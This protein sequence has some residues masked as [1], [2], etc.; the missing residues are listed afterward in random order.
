MIED[1]L[2]EGQ[3]APIPYHSGAPKGLKE[4]PSVQCH[5][6]KV[7]PLEMENA[8]SEGC[9]RAYQKYRQLMSEK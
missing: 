3:I 2:I 7:S 4:L 9:E 6:V 1:Y 5:G 8:L